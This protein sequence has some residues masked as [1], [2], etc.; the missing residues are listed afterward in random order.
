MDLN[1]EVD[2]LKSIKSF[3]EDCVSYSEYYAYGVIGGRQGSCI[4]RYPITSD[5]EL[6][7]RNTSSRSQLWSVKTTSTEPM[8]GAIGDYFIGE[9]VIL[10]ARV[11]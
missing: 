7:K 1:K 2:A 9:N 3:H 4:G 6:A 11:L 5:F 10:I 8:S